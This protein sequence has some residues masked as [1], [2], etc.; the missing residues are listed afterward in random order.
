[1]NSVKTMKATVAAITALSLMNGALVIASGNTNISSDSLVN[2]GAAL[3]T[4]KGDSGTGARIDATTGASV[5]LTPDSTYLKTDAG[6]DPSYTDRLHLIANGN[7]ARVV[8]RGERTDFGLN[9]NASQTGTALGANA[10][11]GGKYATATGNNA[12]AKG[13]NSA[14]YGHNS[15]AAGT[16]SVAIGSDSDAKED[17]TVSIGNDTLKRKLT[18]VADGTASGDAITYDQFS[19]LN[20]SVKTL[21]RRVNKV[22]AGAAALAALHPLDFD[23]GDKMTFAVGYGNYKNAHAAALG[24]FYRPNEDVMVNVGGSLGDGSGL[25]NAGVSF[26]IGQGGEAASSRSALTKKVDELTKSNQQLQAENEAL[27]TQDQT[28]DARIAQ[29]EHQLAVIQHALGK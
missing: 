1:M 29:L 25:V 5:M 12:I 22:G 6:V 8:I 26:K 28:Q 9:T 19:S 20:Q 7:I 24:A 27:R 3:T 2:I 16:N 21:D 11:A 13:T 10:N 17:N 15:T 23:P 14:A 18:N 4:V